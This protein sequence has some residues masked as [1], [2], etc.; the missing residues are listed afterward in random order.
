MNNRWLAL[1]VDVIWYNI[2]RYLTLEELLNLSDSSVIRLPDRLWQKRIPKCITLLFPTINNRAI[3]RFLVKRTECKHEGCLVGPAPHLVDKHPTTLGGPA[4]PHS[5][6]KHPTTLGLRCPCGMIFCGRADHMRPCGLC[7]RQCDKVLGPM[8]KCTN[9]RNTICQACAKSQCVVQNR[10]ITCSGCSENDGCVGCERAVSYHP[11]CSNN[12]SNNE[13]CKLSTAKTCKDCGKLWC[14]S[15]FGKVK[16][17]TCNVL[18][19]PGCLPYC[20]VC[21]EELKHCFNRSCEECTE[22]ICKSCS[23]TCAV[24]DRSLCTDHKNTHDCLLE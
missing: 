1:P 13:E 22:L 10:I 18:Y 5:V 9:C 16:C 2:A 23:V 8:Q 11:K 17:L 12:N 3:C 21:L 14:F 6:D 19:C 7:H 4:P 24:C 20:E 15:C